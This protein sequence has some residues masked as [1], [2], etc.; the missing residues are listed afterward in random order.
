MLQTIRAKL[1]FLLIIIISGISSLGYLLVSNT[2]NA[3]LVAEQ[4]QATGEIAKHASEL[5]VHARGFQIS[6]NQDSIDK[7][8][9]SEKDLMGH[10]QELKRLIEKKE[11]ILLLKELEDERRGDKPSC[12]IATWTMTRWTATK[13]KILRF[14][15]DKTAYRLHKYPLC[16]N[17]T[18]PNK[19]SLVPRSQQKP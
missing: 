10:V 18:T 5:L 2:Q 7:Y 6:N 1:F 3:A 13:I 9:K 15:I 8:H 17:H 4:I 14:N 11:N 16:V 19:A 12:T